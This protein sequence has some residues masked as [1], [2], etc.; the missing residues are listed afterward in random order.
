WGKSSGDRAKF[1]LTVPQILQVVNR[2]EEAGMLDCLQ[3]LHYHIG[4]QLSAISVVKSAIKEASQIYAELVLLGAQMGFLDVGG[5]LAV[6]YNG[7][8]NDSP[9]SKNYNMQNY[10]NDVVATVQDTCEEKNI[11]APILVS[12]SG[13][14]I[15]SHQTILIFDILNSSNI[16][17]VLPPKSA[18]KEHLTLRNLR[19]TYSTITPENCQEA[20]HD[21]VQFKEEAI[22]LFNL[23]YLTLGDRACAEELYW[24]CC[25]KI[26]SIVQSQPDTP[27]DFAELL[28]NMASIYYGNLSIFRSIPDS[29]AI[30]QL[31]PLMPIH[32]LQEQPTKKGVVVDLTCDS[33]G[34]IKSFINTKN[35]PE[36][37]LALHH[38]NNQSYY[39]GLFLI[40]AYQEV[41]G[42]SHNLFGETSVINVHFTATGYQFEPIVAEQII[43]NILP[44]VQHD[45]FELIAKVQKLANS[46]IRNN[47]LNKAQADR[48]TQAYKAFLC[49][50][51]Y[52]N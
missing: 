15:A 51:T 44:T 45:V 43:A 26:F 31:F 50:G 46:E 2:L 40:G 35:N 22:N 4:S 24:S 19:E 20:Y 5:G 11:A 25:Q 14:A 48:I 29:W 32:R 16:D 8:K 1:G 38:S 18:T 21:A 3:L 34:K 42:N 36:N 6:D 28:Q 37:L 39:L 52:L 9:A 41:M 27:D 13:R 49:T 23:G 33:D 7:A 17:P 47:R 10:A 12:E 30:D